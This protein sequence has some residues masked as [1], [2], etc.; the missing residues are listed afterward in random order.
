MM[1]SAHFARP[2]PNTM[3]VFAP[4]PK[5][6]IFCADLRYK[7]V[8]KRK[9][10]MTQMYKVQRNLRFRHVVG[11]TSALMGYEADWAQGTS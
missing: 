7:A 4:H 8:P 3:L 5:P 6:E 10:M 2:Y 11:F 1:H 9:A